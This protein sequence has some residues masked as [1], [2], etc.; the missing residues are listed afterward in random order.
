MQLGSPRLL[1]FAFASADL[2]IEVARDGQIAFAM[3]ASAALSGTA[4]TDLVGRAWRDFVHADDA[5]MIEALFEGLGT[6][7]RNGPVV[8]RLADAPDGKARAVGL[9]VFRLPEND[10]AISC[11]LSM[12]SAEGLEGGATLADRRAFEETTASLLQTARSTGADLELALVEMAGLDTAR[13]EA[14]PDQREALDRRV[15]G[16]LRAQSHGGAAATQLDSEKYALVRARGESTQTLVQ[17][18]AKLMDGHAIT[19]AAEAIPLAGESPKQAL[20]ALRYSLDTF[21]REGV[22]GSAPATL[23]EALSRSMQR[24]L[25]EVGALGAAIREGRFKLVFQPVVSLSDGSLHH[26]ETLVRFG[27]QESPFPQIRMAEEMDLIEALDGAILQRAIETASKRP[28]LR[29]AVNVSGRTIG[30]DDYLAHAT[31]LLTRHPEVRG[32]ILFELT[33]SA[34]LEDMVQADRRL[35]A[36]RA[37]GCEICLDDFGAGAASLAYLQQLSLDVLKIDGRYIRDLQRGGREALFVKHLVKL[38]GELNI[39]TLAEMVETPEAEAICKQAGVDMAQ[40]WLYGAAEDKPDWKPLPPSLVAPV[41]LRPAA[42][43]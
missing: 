30:S 16:V 42:K 10:G 29:L 14:E 32:R 24:T 9:S 38:C 34:A 19:P 33:E 8:M 39:R 21:L 17:R 6:G 26:Y 28:D 31:Q 25:D 41:P 7:L 35:S 43:G 1:G 5:P 36:L 22:T 4:E 18:V 13:E 15:A 12:A 37:Q 11:A 23:A 40:G 20:K 27:D 2:L 3:G